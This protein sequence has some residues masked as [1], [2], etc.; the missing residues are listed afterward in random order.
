MAKNISNNILETGIDVCSL[1][2][3]EHFLGVDLLLKLILK[4]G[5]NTDFILI[6]FILLILL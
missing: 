5:R 3:N 1:I 4:L 6:Y 2:F